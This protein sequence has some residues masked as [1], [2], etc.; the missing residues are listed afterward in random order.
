MISDGSDRNESD[1]PLYVGER[2]KTLA[3]QMRRG[4]RFVQCHWTTFNPSRVHDQ[5]TEWVGGYFDYEKGT[6]PNKWFSAIKTWEGPVT[7][8]SPEH[9]ISRGVKPFTI[10]E[11]F[12][13]KLRFRENDD[14]VRPIVR[15]RP[16]GEP[17]DHVIGYA[18]ERQEGGRGF[19]F[20]GGHV[21]ENWWNA[22]YRRLI[23]NAIVWTARVEV[24]EGGVASRLDEPI[25]M[26]IVTGH[27]HPAHDWRKTTA[28]LITVLEQDPRALVD[29][30]ENPEDL[31]K[32]SAR[33]AP[34][35]R[36]G[37]PDPAARAPST[38][39][40]DLLV[41]NYSSWD[42]AGLSDAA[43]AG[44]DNY[45]KQGGGLSVIHF[46]NGSWTDTL[47]NKAADWPE[48]RTKIVRR[49]WDHKPGLS[50]HDP[51]GSFRVELT[52]TGEKHP[53]TAGLPPFETEDEL[54]FRQ[55]GE[56]PIVPL[57]TA[58]SKV[59]KQDEPL[60]WAYEYSQARVFQTVLGHA[61]VSIRKAGALIR[62]GSVWAARRDNLS[63][64]PPV[65]LTENA[66]FRAG[67][68][69]S[70]EQSLKRAGV[71]A[72]PPDSAGANKTEQLPTTE[73]GRFGN[74]LNAK[75]G[76]AFVNHQETFRQ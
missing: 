13:F 28:A 32:L 43:K 2:L 53:I 4:C 37:S 41:L 20:A 72:A 66:L 34:S 1:H 35:A 17:Q 24:P 10:K 56:L 18:V 54:Y 7:L 22:D 60:A 14:R 12:Y 11:E 8:G 5:I 15:T 31:A 42:R 51:F 19:G 3:R 9:P 21:T 74:A 36:R 71:D 49:V 57:V 58:H 52:A 61:D 69:W 23:L 65:A 40:Y 6:A 67:S 44:L 50:G 70:L 29:V 73:K 68:P 39:D 45:L 38:N 26:L 47:P 55:Q 48:F 27:N 62:R 25:R 64:D 30:T 76:G 59:T 33:L 16:P 46:A 75:A 63:F